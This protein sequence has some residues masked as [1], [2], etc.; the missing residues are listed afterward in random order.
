M[1]IF[2][3]VYFLTDLID[4]FADCLPKLAL[5]GIPSVLLGAV[6]LGML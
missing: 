2:A 3:P 4:C 5:Y 1:N 6:G